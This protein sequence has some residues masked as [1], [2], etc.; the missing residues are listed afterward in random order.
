[1][2]HDLII[3]EPYFSHISSSTSFLSNAWRFDHFLTISLPSHFPS[4]VRGSFMSSPIAQHLHFESGGF[5][6]KKLQLRKFLRK[7]YNC[8]VREKCENGGRVQLYL[9]GNVTHGVF[10]LI[11]GLP[12]L[13]PPWP[14]T[15]KHG[16]KWNNFHVSCTI[17]WIRSIF[18]PQPPF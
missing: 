12:F 8:A 18:L 16:R 17:W 6:I 5:K 7:N 1:M 15:L 2:I 14:P 13:P 3:W 10:C 4:R 9:I 11:Q